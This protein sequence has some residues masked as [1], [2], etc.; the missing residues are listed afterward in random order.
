MI[1]VA[2]KIGI[3]PN[4]CLYF[5]GLITSYSFLTGPR[6]NNSERTMGGYANN[7]ADI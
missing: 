1:T 2:S 3:N 5:G 6:R 7:L 4:L